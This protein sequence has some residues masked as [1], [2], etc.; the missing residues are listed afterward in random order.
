MEERCVEQ[1]DDPDIQGVEPN[2]PLI[3]VVAVMMPQAGR[4]DDEIAGFHV[5]LL[6]FDG[7]VAAL[8][9]DTEAERRLG[10]AVGAKDLAG[11]DQLVIA[12]H[13]LGN[14]VHLGRKARVVH[15]QGAAVGLFRRNQFAALE[16][17]RQNLIEVPDPG[18]AP[19]LRLLRRVFREHLVRRHEM[20]VR[21]ALEKGFLAVV[22]GGGLFRH[23]CLRGHRFS[24]AG[25]AARSRCPRDRSQ[26]MRP[27]PGGMW[28]A[29]GAPS[30]DAPPARNRTPRPH[31]LSV[32][33]SRRL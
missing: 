29:R 21:D 1:G 25:T 26:I 12:R 8:A 19:R 11:K 32:A 9:L 16:Q 10:V 3:A 18:E 6:A 33:G 7:G 4:L 5:D 20:L 17:M 30:R 14:A 22:R 31:T 13:G 27:P 15:Q 23:R 2:Q 28:V 24:L